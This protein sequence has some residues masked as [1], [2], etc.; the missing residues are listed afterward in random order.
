MRQIAGRGTGEATWLPLVEGVPVL[1]LVDVPTRAVVLAPH[2]DD[3]VLAVGGLLRCLARR[4]AQVEV[5]AVTNGE[6]SHPD[7]SLLPHELASLRVHET[8]AALACLGLAGRTTRLGLPDGGREALLA[9]VCE[10]VHL[11]EGDWL[12]APWVGDGHPDHEAVGRAGEQVAARDGARL[13]AFPVWAWHWA[14]A[15]DLP[16]RRAIAHE[17]TPDALSAKQSALGEFRSQVEAL[18]PLEADAPVL[19]EHVLARFRR[20]REVLFA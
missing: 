18:G 14:Q 9:P 17:L 8:E 11:A 10:A 2:P 5:V 1:E 13:L 16:W 7:G 3:E 6:A 12:L 19:P 20:R 15:H 4:G